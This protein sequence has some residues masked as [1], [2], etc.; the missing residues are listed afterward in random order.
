MKKHVWK[1]VVGVI[2]LLFAGSIWYAGE[3]A[4]VANESIVI[5][6][7]TK[8][9]PDAA[10]TLVEYS[11]FQC[12]A[13]A[14]A[15]PVVEEI[16][17]LYGEQV[18]FEYRHFPLITIHPNA[19][20]AAVAAEAAAQQGKF[21]EMHDLL[22]ENQTTWGPTANPTVYFVQYA[23]QLGL[24]VSQFRR[25]I[26]ATKLEDHVRDSFST[27]R[28]LGFTG[29]PT[30]TLNG[31]RV[32]ISSYEDFIA[33]VAAAVGGDAVAPESAVTPVEIPFGI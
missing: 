9:N 2:V 8:G 26:T 22:F 4:K 10:V 14:A 23:E 32:E 12:P 21:F 29:T 11:D 1:I 25:Q 30:F 17:A 18:H 5:E 31:E 20:A 27:A 6:A 3:A 33:Q 13:C 7:R 16:M 19:V 15:V 24:D 28:S